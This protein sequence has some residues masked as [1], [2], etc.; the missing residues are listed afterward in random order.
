M[1]EGRGSAGGMKKGVDGMRIGPILNGLGLT[2]SL[3]HEGAI[4]FDVGTESSFACRRLLLRL[5]SGTLY[6]RTTMHS[7]SR[8]K[9]R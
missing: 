4:G 7:L 6:V 9:N 3:H 8:P 5:S 1:V 2:R